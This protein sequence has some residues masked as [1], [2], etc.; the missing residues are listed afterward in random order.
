MTKNQPYA[1]QRVSKIKNNA[2]LPDYYLAQT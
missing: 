1:D 2:I